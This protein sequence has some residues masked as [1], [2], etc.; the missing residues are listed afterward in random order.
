MNDTCVMAE[1]AAAV[2]LAPLRMLVVVLNPSLVIRSKKIP[3]K[4][5]EASSLVN[6]TLLS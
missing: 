1:T 3:F 6:Y 2:L 4:K 5:E